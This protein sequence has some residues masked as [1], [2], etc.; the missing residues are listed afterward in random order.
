MLRRFHAKHKTLLIAAAH[1]NA[2]HFPPECNVCQSGSDA[3]A[4][5][6]EIIVWNRIDTRYACTA[7]CTIQFGHGFYMVVARFSVEACVCGRIFRHYENLI[8]VCR[9]FAREHERL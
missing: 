2:H 6:P 1:L 5:A 8:G 4:K 3:L 9:G 7:I